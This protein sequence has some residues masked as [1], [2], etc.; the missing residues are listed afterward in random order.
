MCNVCTLQCSYVG[1]SANYGPSYYC[2][3]IGSLIRPFSRYRICRAQTC[4]HYGTEPS[5]LAKQF[6][7]GGSKTS[8][9]L[10]LFWSFLAFTSP[11]SQQPLKIEPYKQCAYLFN[12]PC[13][14]SRNL[15]KPMPVKKLCRMRM[16]VCVYWRTCLFLSFQF[17]SVISF[18]LHIN[19]KP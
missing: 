5:R 14:P 11:I 17:L 1:N 12:R 16:A 6:P 7:H 2:S 9:N 18:W 15:V 8:R 10:H 13:T 4:A 19:C 3:L